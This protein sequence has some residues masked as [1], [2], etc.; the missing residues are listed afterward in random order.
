MRGDNMRKPFLLISAAVLFASI[1]ACSLPS[2]FGPHLIVTLAPAPGLPPQDAVSLELAR[3]VLLGRL[4]SMGVA[5]VMVAVSSDGTLLVSLPGNAN[6]EALTPLM[7]ETGYLVFVD[8]T[9]SFQAGASID[10]SLEVILTGADI[11]SANVTPSS[12]G[13][14][15]IAI[16]LTPQGTQKMA[17]YSSKNIGHYLIIARDGVVISSPTIN[18]TITGGNAIIDGN[19]TQESATT[20]AI[21]LTSGTLPFPLVILKTETK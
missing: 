20:L 13:R 5:N 11:N 19:F 1:L 9:S 3:E 12:T 16:M 10:T 17:D 18:S 2:L 6:L 7:T 4:K 14:Y 21:Q 8:S 15:Q